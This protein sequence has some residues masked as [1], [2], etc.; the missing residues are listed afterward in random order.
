MRRSCEP[1]PLLEP[2]GVVQVAGEAGGL[3]IR[4]DPVTS[5]RQ[6]VVGNTYGGIRILAY[7]P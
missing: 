5:Q 6:L 3:W 1:G 4:N 2:L 7:R